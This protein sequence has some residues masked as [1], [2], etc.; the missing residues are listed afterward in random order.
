[1]GNRV[2]GD[3]QVM[4]VGLGCMNLSHAYGT[5]IPKAAALNLL[6]EASA[7][8]VNHFD[9][10][11]LYGFGANER[12][13]GEYIKPLR[14]RLFLASKCGMA[15]VDGKRVIDGRPA[16]IRAQCEASLKRL[17]TDV[18]D[19]YYLHRKDPKVPIEDSVGALADLVTAG[20]IRHIG[21]SEISAA[22]LAQAQ[23]IHPIAAV[24]N[25]YSLWSRH[26]E[27]GLSR[28]CAASGTT[29]VAFS[30]LARGFLGGVIDLAA[31]PANDIRLGMPRFQS[32]HW[33]Q[34]QALYV[35][36]AQLADA[37][38]ITPAQLALAWVLAQGQHVV[39]IP[40]TT[41]IPHLRA[42][43]AAATMVVDDAIL[44]AAGRLINQETVAG[45]RYPQATLAEIDTEAF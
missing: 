7:L 18:L 3:A 37:A 21:L 32:P 23:A 25:E 41:H 38:E 28:A 22:T 12:L 1:M 39:A 42:N 30:P 11:T 29:L 44:V 33:A 10:A 13:L 20:H 16:T 40:G 35:A 17:Q 31:L 43:V 8:G 27:L 19:L 36:F 26:P 9:T 6:A 14:Q 5:P 15:G 45:P 34:N 24:Q 2:L 4:S